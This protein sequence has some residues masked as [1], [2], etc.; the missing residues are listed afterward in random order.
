ME[1]TYT[2]VGKYKTEGNNIYCFFSDDW[3]NYFYHL[4]YQDGKVYYNDEVSPSRFK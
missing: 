4:Y 3:G 1:N 2:F